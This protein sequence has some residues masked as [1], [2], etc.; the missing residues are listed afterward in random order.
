MFLKAQPVFLAL[1]LMATTAP[2]FAATVNDQGA[3]ELKKNVEDSLAFPL[4]MGKRNNEGL[5]LTGAVEVTP[6]DGYYEVKLPGAAFSAAQGFKFD[7]GTIIAN[8]TPGDEGE[9]KTA[10]SL[11]AI[12]NV[13]DG[14]NAPLATITIGSQK[15][16][17]T[18]IP[19]LAAFTK[20]DAEYKDVAV[21]SSGNDDFSITTGG[22][23]TTL[24]LKKNAD[25]TWSGPNTFSAVNVKMHFNE[26]GGADV[27]FDSVTAGSASDKLNLQSRKVMQDKVLKALSDAS[28]KASADPKAPAANPVTDPALAAAM[29]ASVESFL[30]GMSSSFE[31]ANVKIHANGMAVPEQ[32]A[33]DGMPAIPGKPAVPFD[34]TLAR[35]SSGFDVSGLQEEKGRAGMKLK[36]DGLKVAGADPALDG[37]IP[38]LANFE[39]NVDDLPMKALSHQLGDFFTDL[40]AQ[41]ATATAVP[42]AGEQLQMQHRMRDQVVM[43]MATLPQALTTAG[44]KLSIHNTHTDAPDLQSTLDGDFRADAAAAKMA[45]G[46]LTLSL[47]G[48]DDLV[49]KLQAQ[50]QAPNA[51]PKL[52]GY[53][54]MLSM[55]QLYTQTE[56]GA[57][58]KSVRKLV[59]ELKPDG[60]A[61]LNG[62]PLSPPGR[63]APGNMAPGMTAPAPAPTPGTP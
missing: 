20:V 46:T 6:K 49:Q 42:N 30:D 62:Q 53:A 2:S 21:K 19:S 15:F 28:A 56:Q 1:F 4:D 37:I 11:P 14:A 16:N 47:V 17:G 5:T 35:M 18:W 39:L 23:T 36:L 43:L 55:L 44:T 45:T 25:G 29:A 61:L 59:F 8:V 10:L 9:Y 13:Y 48:V 40:M 34:A 58:G 12:M 60:Q 63:M 50:S 54:T 51:N 57:N 38:T 3:A 31:I 52:A 24:D 22:M 27:A 33:K 41:A 32:P 26:G 7:L